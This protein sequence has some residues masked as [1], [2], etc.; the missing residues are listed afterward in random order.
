MNYEKLK[1]GKKNVILRDAKYDVLGRVSGMGDVS[2]SFSAA[3]LTDTV[4]TVE[5]LLVKPSTAAT[6]SSL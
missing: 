6:Y 2:Y 1:R 5:S 3:R 4:F